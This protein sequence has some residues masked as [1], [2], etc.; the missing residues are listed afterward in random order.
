MTRMTRP[1]CA[2]RYKCEGHRMTRITG[3]I[4]RGCVQFSKFKQIHTRAQHAHTHT[5]VALPHEGLDV[6]PVERDTTPRKAADGGT[7]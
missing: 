4:L 3:P 1:D 6:V 2:V 7:R 5:H